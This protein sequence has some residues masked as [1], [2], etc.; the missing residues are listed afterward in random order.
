MS[1]KRRIIS[2]YPHPT[3][4][5]DR[6]RL[7]PGVNR[8]EEDL[9]DAL[10]REDPRFAN[11]FVAEKLIDGGYQVEWIRDRLSD[12]PAALEASEINA[13]G[14]EEAKALVGEFHE[15]RAALS[16]LVELAE[17]GGISRVFREA[18]EGVSA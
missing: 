3:K 1:W 14:V 17:K 6:L 5:G 7:V 12:D 9:L 16:R 4:Y 8:V 2:T 18:L 10:R 13:I 11:Q 15:D